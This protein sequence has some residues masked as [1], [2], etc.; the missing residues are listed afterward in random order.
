[1]LITICKKF[2]FEAAHNLTWHKG[3]CQNLHG[4]TYKL[5]VYM[6]AERLKDTGIL[7]DFGDLKNLVKEN[8][9]DVLDH[10]NLN[11]HFDNPTAEIMV[12]TILKSLNQL[13]KKIFKV[14]LYETTNSYAEAE[15]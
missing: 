5:E 12:T 11:N 7:M 13:N 6:K 8:I 14:R 15:I 4:H 10:Q 2:E 9:V 3:K 1:M